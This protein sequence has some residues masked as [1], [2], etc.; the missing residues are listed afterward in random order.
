M[1][2]QVSS[3][4][5]SGAKREKQRAREQIAF[6]YNPLSSAEQHATLIAE[7]LNRTT[8]GALDRK[9]MHFQDLS[10]EE[11]F[12]GMCYVIGAT[13]L[14]FR[15]EFSRFIEE[16]LGAEFTHERAIA[17][18]SSFL[19]S[20][21]KKEAFLR[22][23]SEEV[24]GMSAAAM[25]DCLVRFDAF[26]EVIETCGMGGDKGYGPDGKRKKG[27]NASTLSS[28]VLAGLEYPVV[29]HGS[30]G[31]TSAVGSTE[32]M[33]S[34][35]ANT[36]M[37]SHGEVVDIMHK[38]GYCFF[39]AHWCKTIHDL[40]HLLMAETVNHVIGPM[41]PPISS[42]SI[43]H[44]VMGVNEKMH[45]ETIVKAYNILH[46]KGAQSMGGIAVVA[47]LGPIGV[48][49]PDDHGSVRKNIIVD[50]L[51]PFSSVVSFGYGGKFL[52]THVLRPIDFGISV[53]P[54]KIQVENTQDEI[55]R[56][57][58]AALTGK[59]EALADYLAMNAALGLFVY[60][61]VGEPSA[62]KDGKPSAEHLQR[63]FKK[64]RES[65]AQGSALDALRRYV[66]VSGGELVLA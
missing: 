33:E 46:E 58:I 55:R 12:C 27:I 19:T 14:S 65:I 29:K 54:E 35:G 64:C 20:M 16:A 9:L 57:N 18:A 48:L 10:F 53:D 40:S 30:Y 66:E 34:F 4:T 8:I 2:T 32:A 23:T 62:F 41:T 28:L 25:M 49:D 13:N 56:A 1:N 26:P 38:A 5:L 44:K 3:I 45:P 17:M 31:N 47:G 51:S 63:A 15:G 11:A 52:G 36:S 22:L 60:E 43:I 21:A 24:A 61:S 6:A 42:D 7:H 59:N 39:D 37:V 50:E